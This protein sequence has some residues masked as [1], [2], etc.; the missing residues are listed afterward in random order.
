MSQP[1]IRPAT[2]SDYDEWNPL[3]LAYLTFYESTLPRN[4]TERLWKRILDPDHPI[5][6]HLAI[7]DDTIVGLV[8]FFPH[9]H[10]WEESDVCYLQD[11][12]V[13]ETVRTK[14]IGEALIRSVEDTADDEGWKFVYWQTKH[15][16]ARARGLYDKLTG[17]TSGFVVYRLGKGTAKP[18]D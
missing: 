1:T 6:C 17:G 11:L 13:D 15:D 4:S 10:T 5:R 16:N 3:W 14:G 9:V 7:H 12:Y 18:V 2:Q 8:H